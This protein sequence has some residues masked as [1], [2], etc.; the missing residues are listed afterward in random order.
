MIDDGTNLMNSF[1]I[2]N[3]NSTNALVSIITVVYNAEKYLQQAIHSVREQTYD[4]IEYI[5]ID[6]KSVDGTIDIIKKNSD[7]VSHFISEKDNGIYFAMNKGLSI[8]RGSIVGILNAD[9]VLYPFAIEKVV[10]AFRLNP[11]AGYTCSPIDLIDRDGVVYGRSVPL[12]YNRRYSRR[13]MEM[14]CSHQSVF[15]KKIIY[16]DYG[17][18]NTTYR[19]SADY[20]FLL[21]LMELH[22]SCVDI[23]YT[24]AAFRSGG[25][26]ASVKSTIDTLMVHRDHNV[27]RAERYFY[28]VKSLLAK[29]LMRYLKYKRFSSLRR[30]TKSKYSY[31]F[32]W[33]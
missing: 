7:I 28:F 21:R 25:E 29:L 13:Y 32:D 11:H 8:C 2:S 10:E 15:V 17:L 30:F 18:F 16:D 3:R 33:L 14:P 5:I 20:D 26:S 6:G 12:P 19:L 9:D 27:P 24:L 1:S 23:E 31:S 22:I 4:N